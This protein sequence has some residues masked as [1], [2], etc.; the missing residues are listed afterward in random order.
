MILEYFSESYVNFL[1]PA[2][3]FEMFKPPHDYVEAQFKNFFP[4]ISNVSD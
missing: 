3:V 4:S 2:E 1:G